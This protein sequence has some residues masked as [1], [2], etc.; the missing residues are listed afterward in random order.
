MAQGADPDYNPM[1]SSF[2]EHTW[3]NFVLRER[4]RQQVFRSGTIDERLKCQNIDIIRCRRNALAV[5]NFPWSVFSIWDDIKPRT[6][7]RLSSFMFINKRAPRNATEMLKEAPHVGP[8]WRTAEVCAYLLNRKIITW[9]DITHVMRP[10]SKLPQGYFYEAVTKIDEM[11][12]QI[13]DPNTEGPKTK[14]L[15]INSMIGLMAKP[16]NHFYNCR[17]NEPGF[18]DT[19]YEGTK[20]MRV[21]K[22]FGLEQ[23]V[24][25]YEQVSNACMMP[26]HMQIMDH[27]QL[28]LARMREMLTTTCGLTMRNIKE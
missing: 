5:D 13:E 16:V 21:L 19:L 10:T 14:K 26:I 22:E 12:D 17:F 7:M 8:A 9:D 27:E 4:P 11:W 2:N 20:R 3:Q 25:E 24:M 18:D 6:S 1:M 23:M 15:A 28:M